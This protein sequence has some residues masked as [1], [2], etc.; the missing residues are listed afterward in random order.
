MQLV[1]IAN[2]GSQYSRWIEKFELYNI[3]YNQHNQ[4]SSPPL[5]RGKIYKIIDTFKH[6]ITGATICVIEDLQTKHRY[7]IG[8]C[9]L[10]EANLIECVISIITQELI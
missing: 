8:K 7:L 10:E 4:N 9:G 2:I 1:K 6:D 5:Q 3:P